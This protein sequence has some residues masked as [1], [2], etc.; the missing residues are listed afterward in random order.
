MPGQKVAL[1]ETRPRQAHPLNQCCFI[2][3][4][5]KDARFSAPVDWPRAL[6]PPARLRLGLGSCQH[7]QACP[8]PTQ[9]ALCAH[10]LARLCAG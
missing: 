9:R 3:K 5:I 8:L 10:Y 2:E 1:P 6:D 7:W 4:N